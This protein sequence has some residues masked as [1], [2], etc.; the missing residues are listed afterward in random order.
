MF[1]LHNL[2][3]SR[4]ARYLGQFRPN[5]RL[6]L[7][8]TLISGITFSGFQ[9]FFNIYLRSRGFDLDFI[10]LLNAIPSGAA[11]VVGIPMG[12][13]S[14]RIGR[15]RAMLIGLAG[16]TV[17]AWLLVT[18]DSRGVM[19]VMSGLMGIANSL[20]FLSMAPFMIRASGEK[21]RTLLFS[22][23]FG[24]TTLSGAAGNLLAGQLP[25][26]FG[27]WLGVGAESAQAYQAV[28]VASVFGGGLALLPL[29]F[30]REVHWPGP[31]REPPIGLDDFRRLF[32]PSVLKLATPNIIIGFGAAILIPYLNLF[33]K[34]RH[35]I[36]DEALGV[37][38][39]LSALVTGV[40]TVIG[41]RLA[42]WLGGKVRAVV[43]T[44]GASLLFLLTMGFSPVFWL[45]GLA[46]LVRG[47]LMNL[48]NPLYSAFAMERTAERE[49]GAVNSMMQLMWEVGW[50]VGPYLSGVVQA[51]WGFSPL[52]VATAGLYAAAIGLTWLFFRH[53][54]AEPASTLALDSAN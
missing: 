17:A 4:V 38:F 34:G 44:Q 3:N 22:L 15:R 39:S 2:R 11:L 28:L 12:I 27:S 19:V 16:A 36:S 9:L 50:T 51:R 32:R 41:P 20:Y 54:E 18:A 23:N 25:G 10:G 1:F 35:G 46:F 43:F 30:I 7:L 31:S 33:F 8:S 53:A 29:W 42:E 37:L 21:E 14:D 45:S 48:S 47:A 26:W 13:V 24:L 5:A 6:F 52:F 49:R 40:A